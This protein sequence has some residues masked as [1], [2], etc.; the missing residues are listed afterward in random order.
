MPKLYLTKTVDFDGKFIQVT[1]GGGRLR[2]CHLAISREDKRDI[3]RT[4]S[5]EQRVENDVVG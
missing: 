4:T 1:P 3:Q 2:A 5:N